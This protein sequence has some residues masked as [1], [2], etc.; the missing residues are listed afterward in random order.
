M[1]ADP[2]TEPV[3]ELQDPID[4]LIAIEEASEMP[5]R[6]EYVEGMVLV[7]PQPDFDHGNIAGDL[8][9]QL[10]SLD[11]R[12]AGLGMGYRIGRRGGPTRAL[13][14]PDFYVL[15][16][17]PTE[18]DEAYRKAHKGWYPIELLAL[19]GEV[20][21]SNHETDTGPKFR[22]Y[23]TAGIPVYV[24]VHRRDGQVYVHSDPVPDPDDPSRSRYRITATTALGDKV[25]LPDPYPT[26][27]TSALLP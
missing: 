5:I 12:L 9:Y 17:R 27:D 4:L 25:P 2:V 14:I 6:P 20:T 23:A 11:V 22:S 15:R 7:P 10:R 21:S 18:M 3:N 16:R 19:V 26:L 13:V 8:F 1:T 24:L